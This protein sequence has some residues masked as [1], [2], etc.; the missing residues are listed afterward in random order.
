MRAQEFIFEDANPR[1]DLTPNYPN[2]STLVG[3]FLGVEKNR[4]VFRILSAELAPG[5]GAT[6]KIT[7]ALATGRPI[8]IEISRIKNRRVL[9]ELSFRGSQC[10]KDCSGHR[11]GYEWSLR[12]GG[13]DAA[14]WSPSFNKGAWLYKNGY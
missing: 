5:G 6:E 1:V 9:D 14:S 10:T 4:A 2:Y 8:G 11:A 13:A 12:K 3:E 7:K